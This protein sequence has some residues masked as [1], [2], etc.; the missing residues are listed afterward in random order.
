MW[1]QYL[2][3]QSQQAYL[4]LG[5]VEVDHD[6]QPLRPSKN[7][8]DVRQRVVVLNPVFWA[9]D[10]VPEIVTAKYYPTAFV[11][12]NHAAARIF[13]DCFAVA[14]LAVPSDSSLGNCP[15]IFRYHARLREKETMR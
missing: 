5:R 15:Q 4:L 1:Q 13:Y 2:I 9:L 14:A 3:N 8:G 6:V 10:F 11:P 7:Q 12:G